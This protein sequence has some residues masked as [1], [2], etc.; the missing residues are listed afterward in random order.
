MAKPLAKTCFTQSFAGYFAVSFGSFGQFF[1]RSF[2][3]GYLLEDNSIALAPWEEGGGDGD[4][5][6]PQSLL[7]KPGVNTKLLGIPFPMPN[8]ESSPK[9]LEIPSPMLNLESN[10][11]LNSQNNKNNQVLV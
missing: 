5:N 7:S 4:N 1:A 11:K 2:T 6:A 8:L 10:P 9:L 3:T